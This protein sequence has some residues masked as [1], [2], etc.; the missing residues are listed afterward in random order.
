MLKIGDEVHGW[1]IIKQIGYSERTPV[2]IA[3]ESETKFPRILKEYIYD[4]KSTNSEEK[5]VRTRNI[6]N[7]QNNIIQT[8]NI[9]K[10]IHSFQISQ[11]IDYFCTDDGV[12][13]F[14]NFIDGIDLEQ[15]IRCNGCLDETTAIQWIRSIA[16]ILS[17]LHD[18]GIVHLDVKPSNFM[19]DKKGI[20]YAIDLD[21]VKPIHNN[22]VEGTFGTK[23]YAAPERYVDSEPLDARTDI[24]SLGVMMYYFLAMKFPLE[25]GKYIPLSEIGVKV[26]STTEYF[27][28]KC[29][30]A[31][32]QNRFS[33]CKDVIDYLSSPIDK[34]LL[35]YSNKLPKSTKQ[36]PL[37]AKMLIG[38]SIITLL[39]CALVRLNIAASIWVY[40]CQYFLSLWVNR[41]LSISIILTLLIFVIK[42]VVRQ[43]DGLVD[44]LFISLIE[45]PMD[46]LSIVAGYVGAMISL[47]RI[48]H[49][50]LL[51]YI[52]LVI[53]A[54]LIICT[55][56][57]HV[58]HMVISKSFNKLTC[59][60]CMCS[61]YLVSVFMLLYSTTLR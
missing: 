12:V 10:N 36:L 1:K 2:F 43:H 14:K 20:I 23:N 29:L 60:V 53:I 58:E 7:F 37:F 54:I 41:S 61:S 45:L 6:R 47:N 44:K 26:S 48:D 46:I 55:M 4:E 27:I 32:P 28:K 59:S 15:C 57:Y 5:D 24:Y 52:L 16:I 38:G 21:S 25:K 34:N 22:S 17:A 31:E 49:Y 3:V 33:S 42:L 13:V 18:N 35:S 50:F 30:Q 39:L 56:C 51:I 11:V 19:W 40:L 9:V 8:I